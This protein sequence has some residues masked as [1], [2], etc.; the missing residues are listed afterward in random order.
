[1]CFPFSFIKHE[2]KTKTTTDKTICNSKEETSV[3][4]GSA[5][6]GDR[7]RGQSFH[8]AGDGIQP[9]I[10]DERHR[11]LCSDCRLWLHSLYEKPLS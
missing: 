1:M 11:S 9:P 4:A 2:L 5:K 8:V 7:D 3:S 6:D 10:V